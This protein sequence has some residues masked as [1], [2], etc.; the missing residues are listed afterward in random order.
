MLLRERRQTTDETAQT[1]A[2]PSGSGEPAG[3][4][5]DIRQAGAHLWPLGTRPSIRRSPAIARHS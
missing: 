2:N 4:L 1:S 5:H 3:N